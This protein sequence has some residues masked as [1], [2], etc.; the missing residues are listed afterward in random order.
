M[1]LST[2][3]YAARSVFRQVFKLLIIKVFFKVT[4]AMIRKSYGCKQCGYRWMTRWGQRPVRCA[5]KTCRS[6]RW[7]QL[8]VDGPKRRGRPPRPP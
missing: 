5:N 4:Y 7:D 3:Y 8:K 1:L 2:I 6:A